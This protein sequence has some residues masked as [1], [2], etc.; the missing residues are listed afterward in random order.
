MLCKKV[1]SLHSKNE[2]NVLCDDRYTRTCRS[3][4]MRTSIVKDPLCLPVEERQLNSNRKHFLSLFLTYIL[5]HIFCKKSTEPLLPNKG[6][7]KV[8]AIKLRGSRNRR[9][10]RTCRYECSYRSR[11]SSEALE[12]ALRLLTCRHS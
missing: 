9:H 7:P 1:L 11:R 12:D 6:S 3:H 8:L 10:P 4:R 2:G 5:Y